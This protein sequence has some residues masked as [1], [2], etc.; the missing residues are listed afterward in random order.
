MST[1]PSK[2]HGPVNCVYYFVSPHRKHR[3]KITF[4][5]SD[6]LDADCRRDRIEIYDEI[7][8]RVPSKKI[9][10]GSKMVELISNVKD[11]KMRYI[12]NSV[13]K[14]RGF[15]AAVTFL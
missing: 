13:G 2:Y 4:L 12:G 11:I 1:F 14:Y 5:Y 6:I 7:N 10:N 9:C 15:H 8:S 3:V